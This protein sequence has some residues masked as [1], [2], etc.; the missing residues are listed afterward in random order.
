MKRKT[1]RKAK[2]VI[3][4]PAQRVRDAG[5]SGVPFSRG[6]RRLVVAVCIALILAV[7]PLAAADKK[8]VD[9]ALIFGT[10]WDANDRAVA[11]AKVKIR[12]ADQK[13]AEWT[14]I[15]DRR[16]EFAQRVPVGKAEYVVWAEVPSKKGPAAETKVSIESNERADIG[17]HLAP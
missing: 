15:S 10:V 5:A 7:L 8:P 9:Y 16:G 4:D 12:R 13:N 11:G 6:R 14:L 17:L 1:K 2:T 3:S